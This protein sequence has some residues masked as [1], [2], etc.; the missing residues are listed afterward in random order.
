MIT[1]VEMA[2]V[3]LAQRLRSYQQQGR[4][5][6]KYNWTG[7]GMAVLLPRSHRS[8]AYTWVGGPKAN[9][10]SFSRKA[11]IADERGPALVP[12]IGTSEAVFC[13]TG[14]AGV[15]S[16]QDLPFLDTKV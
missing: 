9:N 14:Y 7:Q 13:S 6:A 4:L 2:L 16:E 3:M 15:R 1:K 5:S 11:V 8:G 12:L 10:L